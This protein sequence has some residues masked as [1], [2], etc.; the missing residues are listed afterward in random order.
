M[1]TK[2]QQS[3]A[4]RKPAR[5]GFDCTFCQSRPRRTVVVVNADFSRTPG[6]RI[7]RVSP[8][9]AALAAASAK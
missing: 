6:V 8:R 2:H 7:G 5:I 1:L 9:K 3:L 4:L